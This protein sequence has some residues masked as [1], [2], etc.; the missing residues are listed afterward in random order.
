MRI[1]FQI[2]PRWPPLNAA[3]QQVLDGI[4][5]DR[6]EPQSIVDARGDVQQD[7]D[8]QQPQCCCEQYIIS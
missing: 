7:E 3:Q 6:A 2:Q 5:R 4:E 1:V 8:L